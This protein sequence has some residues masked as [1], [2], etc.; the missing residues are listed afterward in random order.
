MLSSLL[1]DAASM[2][3]Q[4]YNPA[5][6]IACVNALQPLGREAALDEVASELKANSKAAQAIGLFSMLRVLFEVAPADGFPPVLLGQSI[7]APPENPTI[8]PRFPIVLIRDIP[9]LAVTGYILGGLPQSADAHVAYF[10]VHGL[11]R[12]SLL[13][14][15]NSLHGVLEEFRQIWK[16]AYN[17]DGS[18]ML[19]VIKVQCERFAATPV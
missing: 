15:S 19:E 8:L 12:S 13:A 1:S 11:M 10:R 7:P 16:A 2:S 5:I 17:H 4:D 3:P 14:P 6:V 9:F 18:D